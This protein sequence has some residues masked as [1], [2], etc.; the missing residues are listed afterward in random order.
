MTIVEIKPQGFRGK[1]KSVNHDQWS[2]LEMPRGDNTVCDLL[3]LKGVFF[4]ILFF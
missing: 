2:C 1:K 3:F 4:F